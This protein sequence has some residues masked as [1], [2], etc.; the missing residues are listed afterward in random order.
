MVGGD[1]IVQAQP[2][3]AILT[4]SVVTQARSALGRTTAERN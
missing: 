2:D 1:S 4:I 3:T